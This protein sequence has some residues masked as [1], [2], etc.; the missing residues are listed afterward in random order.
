MAYHA[1][2]GR[3]VLFGGYGWQEVTDGG[4]ALQLND[5]WCWDGTA[6]TAQTPSSIP[7]GRMAAPI[8]YD[9]THQ[10][11]V[12]F[13]GRDLWSSG[14]EV[15]RD[16]WV[17]NG[18]DWRHRTP[19][20]SPPAR[21]Y[22]GLAY[23]SIRQEAVL[24]GGWNGNASFPPN[25]SDTWTWD[26]SNWTQR[27]PQQ[28][29][30]VREDHLMVYDEARKQ[31]VLFGGLQWSYGFTQFNDTW[32]W[33]GLNW[34]KQNPATSPPPIRFDTITYDPQT[35]MVLLYGIGDLNAN[36]IWGW[37]GSTWTKLSA[38]V[39][40]PPRSLSAIAADPLRGTV[41]LF[42]G[43]NRG[44]PPLLN[45]TWERS[46]SSAGLLTVAPQSLSFAYSDGSNRKPDA[47]DISVSSTSGAPVPFSV[48]VTT[49]PPGGT[50][51]QVATTSSKTPGKI[52]VSVAPGLPLGSY[53]GQV[54]VTATGVNNSSVIVPVTLQVVVSPPSVIIIDG[55]HI[56]SVI[57]PSYPPDPTHY[58]YDAIDPYWTGLIESRVG[59]ITHFDWSRNIYDTDDY[60]LYLSAVL[61]GL[62][63]ANKRNHSPLVVV[64]HSWGTVLAYIAISRNKNIVVDKFVT[65]GS[66]LNAQNGTVN[67]FTKETLARWNINKISSPQNVRTWTNYWA[68]CDPISGSIPAIKGN[69]MITTNYIDN[70]FLTCH[71]A[72]YADYGVWQDILFYVYLTK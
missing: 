47:Q 14:L 6:W 46:Q 34:T 67:A 57:N 25:L 72:Y 5:T 22:T 53:S 52:S 13:G 50:W 71:G 59:T 12:M 60:V 62:T 24:Y 68:Q 39:E 32:T 70:E 44:G 33:D 1:A 48:S 41:V 17:W 30:G 8:T 9:Q 40:P 20:T 49:F 3:T 55:T 19:V 43:G 69:I 42:G 10:E 56:I 4:H 38:N 28:N 18:Q 31:T 66:P 16:T 64:S 58:L 7:S 29:P 2:T 51:L 36:E 27:F 37:N 54:I 45:D 11:L 35:Q 15:L 23:D 61:E 65:L 21:A 26:G 63:K